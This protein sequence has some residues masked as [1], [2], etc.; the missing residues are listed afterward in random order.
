MLQRCARKGEEGGASEFRPILSNLIDD[1]LL[2]RYLI[3]FP[4][5]EM[6]LHSLSHR[7][8]SCVHYCVYSFHCTYYTL[9]N[10]SS[11]Y[12]FLFRLYEIS[13]EVTCLEQALRPSHKLRQ[14]ILPRLF[15]RLARSHRQLL[16]LFNTIERILSSYLIV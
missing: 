12:S 9:S 2:V 14:H 4:A 13:W 11:S 3:E 15:P 5:A 8:S 10:T 6:I 1:L 16:A 7:V